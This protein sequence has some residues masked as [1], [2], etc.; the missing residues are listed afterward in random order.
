MI[1]LSSSPGA[2]PEQEGRCQ[3]GDVQ[4]WLQGQHQA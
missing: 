2:D 3:Q 1:Y 4:M